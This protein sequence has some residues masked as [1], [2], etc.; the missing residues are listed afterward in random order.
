MIK[1]QTLF[2][3]KMFQYFRQNMPQGPKFFNIPYFILLFHYDCIKNKYGNKSRSLFV[4]TY[5][6]MCEIKTENVYEEFSED[7]EMFGFSNYSVKS[8]HNDYSKKI[9]GW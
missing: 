5:S 3:T 8:E 4:Y 6:L 9:S 1:N 7:K 2:Y